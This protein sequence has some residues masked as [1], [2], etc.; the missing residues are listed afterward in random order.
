M[1]THPPIISVLPP[2]LLPHVILLIPILAI[3]LVEK[4]T[5][6]GLL[7]SLPL[8]HKFHSDDKWTTR[9]GRWTPRK[10]KKEWPIMQTLD[11]GRDSDVALIGRG[12]CSPPHSPP[13]S[14]HSSWGKFPSKSRNKNNKDRGK[15]NEPLARSLACRSR[16]SSSAL[17]ASGQ[18]FPPC[19]P[20]VKMSRPRQMRCKRASLTLAQQQPGPPPLLFECGSVVPAVLQCAARDGSRGGTHGICRYGVAPCDHPSGVGRAARGEWSGAARRLVWWDDGRAEKRRLEL[21]W[22]G[23]VR[24]RGEG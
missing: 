10:K 5:I 14:H 24:T 7:Q 17:N 12:P 9:K 4:S 16:L 19:S 18:T 20:T 6:D 11:F 21:S 15:R 3:L 8:P 2:P 22:A 1:E 13:A 23:R